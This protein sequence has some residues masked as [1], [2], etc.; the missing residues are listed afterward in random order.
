M[1]VDLPAEALRRLEAEAA[2][3]GVE[4]DV[5]IAE[6]AGTLP[7]SGEAPA[8]RRRLAISGIGASGGNRGPCRGRRRAAR[9]RLRS[10]LS[11]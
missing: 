10:Q 11:I 6:L 9:R 3:R 4:I 5:V 1:T 2:R 7:A 8:R